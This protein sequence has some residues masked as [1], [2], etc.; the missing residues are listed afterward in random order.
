MLC[1]LLAAGS[2]PEP[3]ELEDDPEGEVAPEDAEA[4]PDEDG[5]PDEDADPEGEPDEAEGEGE[6]V[7]EPDGEAEAEAASEGED[8]PA[9]E[10]EAREETEAPVVDEG[11]KQMG[12]R[13]HRFVY[14]NLSAVRYNPLGLINEL[15]LGWRIQLINKNTTLFK[16]SFIS[17]NLHT[18]ITPA[19]G[20]IGPMVI[21]QPLAVLN[22]SASYDGIGYFGTFDL[23]QSYP[24]P[25]ANYSDS[26]IANQ[27]EQGFDQATRGHLITLSAL[28]QAKVGRIAM[29]DNVKGYYF[30]LFLREDL[31][32]GREDPVSYDQTLDILVPDEGW[33]LTNDLDLLYLFD[34]GLTLGARYTYTK[35][36]YRDSDFLPGEPTDDP[37]GGTHRI[38]PAI[39]Y[40]PP[41]WSAKAARRH[42]HSTKRWRNPTVILL[43]QWWA[44]HR[45]RTG[46]DVH[47]AVPYL[48]LALRFEGDFFP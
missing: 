33:S 27:G 22:L 2:A 31:A 5:E 39:L 25:R 32:T 6:G 24:S 34:F 28:L 37:N 23:V 45:W 38:G 19:F 18:Y 10:A 46:A 20:R 4:E 7:P 8:E 44:K 40:A 14:T 3:D 29:R 21:F 12:L 13:R 26:E 1:A 11:R 36:F 30:D 41:K 47:P 15:T 43:P 42:N 48:V 17:L 16:D 9:T 35:A